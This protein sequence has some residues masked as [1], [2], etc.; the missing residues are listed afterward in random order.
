MPRLAVA[1]MSLHSQEWLCHASS[2]YNQ[3]FRIPGK[4]K[5]AHRGARAKFTRNGV[6]YG[7]KGKGECECEEQ[8]GSFA[9]VQ[10]DDVKNE[11][12]FKNQCA[13]LTVCRP[14]HGP[15]QNREPSQK[16]RQE[17]RG[18]DLGAYRHEKV[19]E[20]CFYEGEPENADAHSLHNRAM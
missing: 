14:L 19:L 6:R 15:R 9:S 2:L 5:G 20:L 18:C 7:S 13:R 11:A 12:K 8:E 16:R 10:D 4:V 3:A 1:V 17:P